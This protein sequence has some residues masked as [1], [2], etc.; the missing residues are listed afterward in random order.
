MKAIDPR[1]IRQIFV[2]LL[3]L[4]IGVGVGIPLFGFIGLIFGPLLVNLFLIIVRI[5]KREY[6]QDTQ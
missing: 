5:Y 1:I 6:G 3:I 2:L 4:L